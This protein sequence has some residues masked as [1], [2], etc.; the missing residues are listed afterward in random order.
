MYNV[1]L[2]VII[3]IVKVTPLVIAGPQG[4]KTEEC[5][6]HNQQNAPVSY[7]ATCRRQGYSTETCPC[8]Q[9]SSGQQNPSQYNSTTNHGNNNVGDHRPRRNVEI[10]GRIFKALLDSGATT[11]YVNE[12][13]SNWLEENEEPSRKVKV[14]TYM[15]NRAMDCSDTAYNID[16]RMVRIFSN[17]RDYGRYHSR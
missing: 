6:C 10:L 2:N 8:S 17:E 1:V 5:N 14:Y 3:V 13:V 7:C 16:F 11:S 15:A 9:P 4:V 12:K